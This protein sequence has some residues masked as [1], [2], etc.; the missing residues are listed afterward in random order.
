MQLNGLQKYG[1]EA[2]A[3]NEDGSEMDIAEATRKAKT[4]SLTPDNFKYILEW[5][6]SVP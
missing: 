1:V 3:I 5:C 2:I 4:Y 6:R